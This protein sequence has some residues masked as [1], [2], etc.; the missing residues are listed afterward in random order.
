MSAGP[1][2][3]PVRATRSLIVP[4]MA[5]LRSS[6]TATCEQRTLWKSRQR[7]QLSASA[8]CGSESRA[9][10]ASSAGRP[11]RRAAGSGMGGEA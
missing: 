6:G 8:A 3:R 10:S 7:D 2:V 9:A 1:R 4:G 5:P 11:A